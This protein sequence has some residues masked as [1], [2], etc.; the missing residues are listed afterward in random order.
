MVIVPLAVVLVVVGALVGV[1]LFGGS[2]QSTA[3]GPTPT[4]GTDAVLSAV[5][6]VPPGVLDQV[7]VGSGRPPAK[8]SAPPL[9]A[10]G[11]PKVLYVGAEYC[12]YCAAERWSMVVALSRFGTF[13]GLGQTASTPNDVYPNTPTLSF[14][15]STYTSDTVAFTAVE[16]ESNEVVNGRY[17]P[18]DT[19]SPADQQTFQTYNA[20]P[21]VPNAGSIPFVDIGGEYLVSG[22][23]YSPDVLKGKTH[24][25]VARALSDPHSPI[26]QGIDGTANLITAAICRTTKDAPAAVCRTGGVQAAAGQLS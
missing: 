24:E 14:H 9:S 25:Q 7:G 3:P 1:R 8:I 12:P 6:S 17:A 13:S 20:P 2:A 22:A 10:D 21:Y 18:L 19:L 16:T 5:T 23:S 4:S 11:K 15:G 26:A